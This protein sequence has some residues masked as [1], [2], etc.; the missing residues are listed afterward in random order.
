MSPKKQTTQNTAQQI[1]SGSVSSYKM[2]ERTLGVLKEWSPRCT[3][4]QD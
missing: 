1:Y 2:D 4:E 3:N